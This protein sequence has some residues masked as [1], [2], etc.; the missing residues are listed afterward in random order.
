MEISAHILKLTGKAE[1][2][3]EIEAGHNY[4]VSLSGS[5]PSVTE[6]DNEDGTFTR[7]YTFRPVKIELLDAQGKTLKLKDARSKSQ[8][9]RARTWSQWKD[10]PE[11]QT[12]EQFYDALMDNLINFAPEVIEMYGPSTS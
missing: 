10:R 9:F 7:T 2:P 12:F 11:N 8:L 3:R 1:L 6:S 4:H 5:I